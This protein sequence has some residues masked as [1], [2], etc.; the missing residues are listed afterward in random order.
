MLV[1]TIHLNGTSQEDLL[2]QVTKAAH[3]VYAAVEA[4]SQMAPNG[5]D[6]YPQGPDALPLAL[7]EHRKRMATLEDLLQELQELSEAIH[8]GG[9][10]G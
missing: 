10:K 4:L 7:R 5:R 8:D 1:P 2:T 6:Y 3:A 9:H